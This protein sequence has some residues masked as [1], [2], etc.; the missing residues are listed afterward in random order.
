M[1]VFDHPADFARRRARALPLG[2]G[3]RQLISILAK[4]L[5][6]LVELL[7]LAARD[8]P[9]I[10]AW[11]PALFAFVNDPGDFLQRESHRLRFADES[12]AHEDG[13]GVQAIAGCAAPRRA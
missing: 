11:R 1:A 9:H 4:L 7:Q 8:P 3:S 13:L 2:Q 12:E 6:S 5:Q 10:G